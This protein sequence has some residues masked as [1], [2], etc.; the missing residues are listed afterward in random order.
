MAFLF[1]DG[2]ITK[3][4]GWGCLLF[5]F[6]LLTLVLALAGGNEPVDYIALVIFGL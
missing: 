4:G 6:A 5:V 2:M 1:G 3:G